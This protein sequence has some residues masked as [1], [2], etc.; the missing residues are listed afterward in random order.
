MLGMVRLVQWL[1]SS[2]PDPL[3]TRYTL[4]IDSGTG[5]SAVGAALGVK[6][7]GLP[8]RVVGV[9]LAGSLE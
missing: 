4:V 8:W 3:G 7:L 2:L 9:M 1:A 5:T 6:L